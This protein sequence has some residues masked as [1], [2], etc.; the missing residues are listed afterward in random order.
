M[1]RAR[2]VIKEILTSP[3]VLSSA[4]TVCVVGHVSTVRSLLTETQGLTQKECA[5]LFELLAPP[6]VT[7]SSCLSA[8]RGACSTRARRWGALGVQP[9]TLTHL[10]F[11]PE[12][13]AWELEYTGLAVEDFELRC[14]SCA[15]FGRSRA[16]TTWTWA[17]A[18]SP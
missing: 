18:S 10:T 3:R 9:N 16:A 6:P 2:Q 4:N 14:A 17:T 12:T 7:G 13:K 8:S 5:G 11:C 15:G 1:K